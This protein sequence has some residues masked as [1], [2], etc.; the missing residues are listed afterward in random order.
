[1]LSALLLSPPPPPPPS[2]SSSLSSWIH[3]GLAQAQHAALIA[4]PGHA[5]AH[6]ALAGAMRESSWSCDDRG[7]SAD[8]ATNFSSGGDVAVAARREHGS[9]GSPTSAARRPHNTAA[10]GALALGSPFGGGDGPGG[11]NRWQ[12]DYCAGKTAA[13]KDKVKAFRAQRIASLLAEEHAKQAVVER[14]LGATMMNNTNWMDFSQTQQR[15][16][17]TSKPSRKTNGTGGGEGRVSPSQMVRQLARQEAAAEQKRQLTQHAERLAAEH[18]ELERQLASGTLTGAEATAA[19]A[20]LAAIA[21]E[22]VV[23]RQELQR[24]EASRTNLGSDEEDASLRSTSARDTQSGAAARSPARQRRRRQ[25]RVTVCGYSSPYA[26]SREWTTACLSSAP[27]SIWPPSS[28]N[29]LLL[30]CA[31]HRWML[32]VQEAERK[33]LRQSTQRA[34]AAYEAAVLADTS[35]ALQH[36]RAV[37]SLA[38]EKAELSRQLASGMLDEEAAEAARER[39]AAIEGMIC[40]SCSWT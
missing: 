20:R 33:Q 15:L 11:G 9:M 34:A 8:D 4:T 5:S 31:V 30:L 19:R 36:E 28:F 13:Q 26:G 16:H 2:Y 17:H 10:V 22:Q 3:C 21:T 14:D 38:Q 27:A 39:L 32:V 23:L 12:G 40:T 37:A 18:D 1:M 24:L 7:L 25:W 29:L 6:A 35:R